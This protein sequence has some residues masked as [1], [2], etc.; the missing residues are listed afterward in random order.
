MKKISA[1][2]SLL[3]IGALG[4]FATSWFTHGNLDVDLSDEDI[5]LYL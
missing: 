4:L 5:Q 3:L 2:S 1:I